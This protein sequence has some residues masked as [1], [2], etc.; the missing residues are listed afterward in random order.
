M[1]IIRQ[2]ARRDC[3]MLQFAREYYSYKMP[4]NDF[5]VGNADI[6]AAV[7]ELPELL[8][9][10]YQLASFHSELIEQSAKKTG[11]AVVEI[12]DS[13]C[14]YLIRHFNELNAMPHPITGQYILDP[15]DQNALHDRIRWGCGMDSF[16]IVFEHFVDE[17]GT[18][19][20]TSTDQEG[21]AV[22]ASEI[23]R[24]V[25]AEV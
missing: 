6:E 5:L 13:N 11:V 25:G 10:S 12:D 21:R 7:G 16:T 18:Y 4:L 14:R 3:E 22:S 1:R 19:L 17:F 15:S 23:A 24:F 20:N 8:R 2:E 9:S